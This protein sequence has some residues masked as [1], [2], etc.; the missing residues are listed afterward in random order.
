MSIDALRRTLGRRGLDVDDAALAE[1]YAHLRQS[2]RHA[3]AR[4]AVGDTLCT[5]AL[6]HEAWL[7]LFRNPES[8]AFNDRQHFYATAALAMRYLIV[9]HI[10]ARRDGQVDLPDMPQAA[11]QQS[12][13]DAE[14]ALDLHEA[15]DAMAARHPR[16]ARVVELRWF[17]GF[18]EAETADVLGVTDRTVRRDW[19]FAQAWLKHH[20]ADRAQDVA[21]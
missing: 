13:R 3:R 7:K 12:D 6:V 8:S 15:L 21:P 1:L 9:D 14:M 5:T 4:H 17:I 11:A 16:Q 18:D 20:L 10:R 19:V 2:A